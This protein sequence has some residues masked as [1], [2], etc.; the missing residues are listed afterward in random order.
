MVC[1]S[2]H[3]GVSWLEVNFSYFEAFIENWYVANCFMQDK[4]VS[5]EFK[6]MYIFINNSTNNRCY[7][8]IAARNVAETP[9][10]II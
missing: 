3:L 7:S 1:Y 6:K 8:V 4:C 9:E 5:I 2:S 10:N